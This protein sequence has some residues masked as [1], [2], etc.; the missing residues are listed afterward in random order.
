M[1]IPVVIPT[2]ILLSLTLFT[3]AQ[4]S[5][6]VTPSTGIAIAEAEAQKC[7]DKIASVQRD[8]LY[9]Y[10]SSLQ[11]LQAGFQK[12][13]D[14]E[15]ALAVRAERQRA[16]ADGTLTEADFVSEPK[17]LRALQAQTASKLQELISQLVQESAPKL[18][19]LKKQLTVAG[20]LDEA[21]AIRTSIEKLQ[22]SF[23]P[24]AHPDSKTPMASE[25]ILNAYAADH[26]RADAVYKGQHLTVHG[27]VAGFRTDLDGHHYVIFMS[28][29]DLSGPLIQC[30]F[31]LNQYHFRE[32]KQLNNV[33]LTVWSDK[34]AGTIRVQRG[35]AF[36]V[37]GTCSG[38]DDGVKLQKCELLH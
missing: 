19:E 21:L 1:K 36:S 25:V 29:P 22:A 4:S 20:K 17:A 24:A 11:E 37:T 33:I 28:G 2:A 23:M 14:L 10:D 26:G 13:A 15:G 8:V 16:A 34:E 32:D 7:Q 38:W 6:T 27:S 18:I 3:A 12:A 35:S 9:R 31:A 5:V 30:V